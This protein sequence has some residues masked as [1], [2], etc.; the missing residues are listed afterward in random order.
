MRERVQRWPMVAP[1]EIDRGI[2]AG[3]RSAV[4]RSGCRVPFDL[5]VAR[6]G[7]PDEPQNVVPVGFERRHERRSEQ[8]GRTRDDDSHAAGF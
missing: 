5:G 7:T 3:E 8:A 6:G 1:L 4:D 2:H